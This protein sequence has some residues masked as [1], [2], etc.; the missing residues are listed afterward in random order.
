ML[1]LMVHNPQPWHSFT[2]CSYTASTQRIGKVRRQMIERKS[3]EIKQSQIL[4]VIR[5]SSGT[6][7]SC[8]AC[9]GRRGGCCRGT[10]RRLTTTTVILT[11]VAG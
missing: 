8:R 5:M 6:T 1:E 10:R 2:C 3:I 11:V 9:C 7:T 4:I